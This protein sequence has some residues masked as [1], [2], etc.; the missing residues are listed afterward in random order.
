MSGIIREGKNCWKASRASRAAFLVDAASYYRAFYRAVE[1]ARETVYIL[2]W[3]IDS[4]VPLLR[5]EEEE[6]GAPVRLGEFINRLARRRKLDIYI[7][8][9]DPALIYRFEREAF[10]RL[11]LGWKS[12]RRVRFRLDSNHPLGSSLHQKIVVIDDSVA[13][14][15]GIDL[16]ARRWDT[17]EHRP[18]DIR[19]RDPGGKEYHPFHDLQMAVSGEAAARLGELA[20]DRWERATGERLNPPSGGGNPW[21]EG[22]AA[23]LEDI[24]VALARTYPPYRGRPGIREAETLYL[25]AI[26]AARRT[27]YIENQYFTSRRVGEALARRLE[28]KDGPEVVLVLPRSCDGWLEESTMGVLRERRLQAL[29]NADRYGRLGVY[30]P[31]TGEETPVMV[32]SKAMIVDD[33]LLRIGSANLSNRS[34]GADVEC[35]LALERRD[36]ETARV[37]SGFRDRLLAEHLGTEPEEFSRA[38]GRSGSLLETIER[39]QGGGRG[40]RP[41]ETEELSPLGTYLDPE[42][43]A[44]PEQP[45]SSEKYLERFLAPSGNGRKKGWISLAFFGLLIIAAAVFWSQAGAEE[46]LHLES[47]QDLIPHLRENFWGPLLVIAVFV[48]GGLVMA[49]VTWMIVGTSLIFGPFWGFVYS[50]AGS[51]LSAAAAY[52]AGRLFWRKTIDRLAGRKLSRLRKWLAPKSVPAIAII[53]NI[54]VAPYTVVNLL[55]GSM[56]IGF[57]GFILGTAIGMFPG[58]I[59]LVFFSSRIL[60]L[61]RDP[62][63]ANILI[64]SGALVLVVILA[65]LLQRLLNR[66]GDTGKKSGGEDE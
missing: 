50:L 33:L 41:L 65:A 62:S 31:V 58:M 36:E 49:P 5:G 30:Y 20:R 34:L 56:R 54:P 46:W 6:D 48:I 21:P 7:L 59:A 47:F 11:S 19:R 24:P 55:A 26:A 38:F 28:E 35:D 22:L 42:F 9:W 64:A 57:G 13:F 15:G 2:G 18:G 10:P 25:D 52:L 12:P 4:R 39:F 29:K 61:V 43:L 63:A 44:D 40:L 8:I 45:I 14:S 53:R 23:D 17:P 16:T 1:N 60:K 32:H 66:N 3:D 27:I 51:L 37:I